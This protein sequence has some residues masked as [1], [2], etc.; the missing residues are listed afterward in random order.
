MKVAIFFETSR[1]TACPATQRHIAKDFSLQIESYFPLA[2]RSLLSL[3]VKNLLGI[4]Y[5]L[6]TISAAV[7]MFISLHTDSL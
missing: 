4:P 2:T 5:P 6:D 7:P 3:D 1:T